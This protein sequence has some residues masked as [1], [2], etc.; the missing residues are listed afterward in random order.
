[1]TVKI[2][3]FIL[4]AIKNNTYL[5]VDEATRLAALVDPA[6]S[7]NQIPAMLEEKGLELCY[8]LITHAHFDH[9]GGVRWMQSLAP[10]HVPV[11][12]HALDLNLW[13]EGG[14]SK[15]FGF[16]FDP[17]PQPDLI[18]TDGQKL[19][20]GDTQITVLH[21]PGHSFG[22]VTYHLGA[23]RVAFC[24]DLIFYHGIGRTD[25]DV[26]NEDDLFAS[27]RTKILTLPDDTVLYPGHGAKT[28]VGEERVNNPFL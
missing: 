6:A 26:C 4:G 18:V 16:D 14:G 8:M 1:M 24:G 11:A 20:L 27:I 15:D 17:G 25:L 22:H 13:N 5:I 19:T 28:T 21:T 9:I 12:L 23:E 7:T 3:T 2:H 10:Q